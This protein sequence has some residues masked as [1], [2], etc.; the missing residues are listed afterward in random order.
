MAKRQHFQQQL[1]ALQA[2][3]RDQLPDKVKE[4]ER[5]WNLACDRHCSQVELNALY[6]LV[7][8]L[9][10]SAPTFGL[11][12]ITDSAHRLEAIVKNLLV[13]GELPSEEQLYRVQV[14]LS[15]LK[16]FSLEAK[17]EANRE[18][19]LEL[20]DFDVEFSEEEE[21]VHTLLLVE[22]SLLLRTR[23]ALWLQEEGYHV[24]EADNGKMALE[25]AR[26]NQPDLI[27]MDVM[28]PELNGL[29]AT[30]HL[31][32]DPELADIPVIIL[33]TLIEREDVQRALRYN[34][35]D[36]LAKPIRRRHL[37][38]RVAACLKKHP[39]EGERR[40]SKM[41]H[42]SNRV[43]VADDSSL[44]RQR[45]GLSLR[46]EGFQVIEADNGKHALEKARKHKPD[47]ILMDVMMPEM[48]GLE[49]TMRIREEQALQDLPIIIL[50]SRNEVAD[51]QR[52][53][54]FNINDYIAKPFNQ[55][56]LIDRVKACLAA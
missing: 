26:A 17:E 13:Y 22:D 25:M 52:A 44:F 36:F 50:T 54:P 23:I 24:L 41:A 46:E 18:V 34:I 42:A 12:E 6:Q 15:L 49:A 1:A 14:D 43:L 9:S 55:D 20:E 27:L 53:I 56:H 8:K 33:T 16:Y 5:L 45:I 10:G 40:L 39:R 21:T 38:Q 11:D 32:V 28:M 4:I 2:A 29:E 48:D 51:V 37:T 7:H 35:D 30:A 47:L 31:R 3:Y 19:S